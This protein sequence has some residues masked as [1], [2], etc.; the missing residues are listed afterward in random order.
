MP[1]PSK[2]VRSVSL[3]CF[4]LLLIN[5][6]F[7]QSLLEKSISVNATNQKLS[8]VLAQ[9]SKQGGFQFS[10]SGKNFP[11]DSLV[12]FTASNQMVSKMLSQLLSN[13]YEFEERRNYIIITPALQR[14]SFI[15]TDV[16][17][18]DNNYSISGIVVNE[19]TK[20]RLMN[21]SVYEKEQLVSTITD[22]HGYFKLKLKSNSLDQV[23]ITA[24][25][26][27]YRD[28]SLSFLNTVVISNRNRARLFQHNGRDVEATALGKFFTTAAQRIQSINIQDF[29]ANRP[30]QVSITPGLSSHGALSSQVV[31]KFSLN[32]AGGYT[33]GV[34]GLEIGGL[35]NINKRD[36]RYLQF[37]GVFNLVGGTVTGLQL[38][39]VSNQTLDTVKGAQI[40]GFI[41]TAEGQVSGLQLAT[42][43]NRTHKLKGVQIGLVNI[44]DTSK[45]LSLGLLN[46]IDNGFYRVSMSAS[47]IMPINFSFASGTRDFYTIVHAGA[48]PFAHVPQ[49]SMG[50][51]IGH[52]F[53]FSKNVFASASL[54]YH[55]SGESISFKDKLKQG[56][57]LLNARLSEKVSVHAGPVYN[58]FKPWAS[59]ERVISN[60]V[61]VPYYPKNN[62]YQKKSLGW[63][64]G[65][66]FNSVFKPGPKVK[67]D[68]Q[69]WYLGIAV[70]GGVDI[71]APRPVIGTEVYTYRNL[72][73]SAAATL[74]IGYTQ[75]LAKRA[76]PPPILDP[77]YISMSYY[78]DHD[79]HSLPIKVGIRTYTGKHL[80][81]GAKL[82]VQVALNDP[83][84]YITVNS[85]NTFSE[86]QRGKNWT[87]FIASFSP[88]YAFKNGLEASIEYEY[89]GGW[90]D[91]QTIMIRVGYRFK[92]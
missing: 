40:A 66:A 36:T 17:S 8:N 84:T 65:I 48:D 15:N 30:Y 73:Q 21:T 7:A 68:V 46:I 14:L 22:E 77:G 52:D 89:Y 32:L 49:L 70:L 45:G 64:A 71:K 24:S 56:K 76:T 37:A 79:Y 41:N 81:F 74:S 3:S 67:Y 25:K 33:A 60:D 4:F 62:H 90:Q 42:L 92:L 16:T 26:Y 35:F 27:A 5:I 50:I 13:K 58:V 23:R 83:E 82:G 59:R 80:F 1:I 34:D 6:A 87:S 39:G 47:S 44:A 55:V 38:A 72:T 85:D 43:N 78:E 63:E 51:G 88:G 54:N 12:S 91:L 69:D 86:V 10:Y 75:H 11:K 18:D 53:I 19:K 57:I 61:L 2:I 9:I 31:N 29:F 28:T 20:G